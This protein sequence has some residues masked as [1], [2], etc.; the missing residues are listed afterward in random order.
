MLIMLKEVVEIVKVEGDKVE[1]EFRK[2]KMCSCCRMHYLCGKGENTLLID[3]RDFSLKE[4]DKVEV[5]IDERQNILANIIIFLIPAII[6]IGSLVGFKNQGEVKS[7]FLALVAVCLYYV[8]VKLLL[9]KHGR[10][11][12]IK[13]LKK[14]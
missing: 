8:V 11:F 7:F 2:N 10:K 9:R 6:F 3:N 13:I 14:L 12:D 1:I 5:G 4:G